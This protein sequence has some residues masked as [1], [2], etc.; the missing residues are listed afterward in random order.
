MKWAVTIVLFVLTS[1]PPALAAPETDQATTQVAPVIVNG[2]VLF[3][4]RGVTAYPAKLRATK[5]A[6]RIVN[7]AE[8]VNFDPETLRIEGNDDRSKI[9]AGDQKIVS[10]FDDDAALEGISRSVLSRAFLKKIKTTIVVYRQDRTS[11]VLLLN[12]AYAL[13]ATVILIVLLF[14]IRWGFRHLDSMLEHQ[15]KRRIESLEAKSLR[16]VQAE[17]IWTA[18]RVAG[19][20]VR[21]VLVLFL[22]YIYLNTVLG[23][24]PWTRYIGRTLLSY[25]INPLTTMGTAVIE[26]LPKLF[27]LIFLVIVSRYILKITRMFFRAIERKRLTFSGFEAEWAWPTY[28]IVRLVVFAFTIII[29][30]P[31][32]PGSN[33]AAFKGVSLF[34]GILFS[35]G[36]TSVIGNVIAGYTMTYRRAFHV[37]DR[38]RIGENM[39]EVTEMRLLVTHMRTTKNEEVVI[40]NSIILNN[41]VTNYSTMAREQGLIL[42]TNVGIGY[43]V[44]WRQVEAMLLMAAQRTPGLRTDTPPFVLQKSLGDFEVNYELNVYCDQVDRMM[45]FYTQLHRNIQ[46]VFNE[47]GVQIMTPAYE[48][49]TPEPKIVPK[50]KWYSAPAKSPET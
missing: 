28:R 35:L 45:Q 34:F 25:V 2:E 23:L 14:G 42:H 13:A 39:G 18:L 43:E 12:A 47:Y 17:Q 19:R 22:L 29:A 21:T 50:D 20:L 32:I 16:I 31:Y 15:L 46:D 49:D 33:S 41:E 27:F 6:E 4:V 48:N 3:H 37:G 1:V 10:V 26:Y 38:V 30:Y 11:S 9:M 7:L 24:F 5:I 8:D 36:S 40:P 44:P